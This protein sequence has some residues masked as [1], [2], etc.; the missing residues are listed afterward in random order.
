MKKTL[1]LLGL[2]AL[3]TSCVSLTGQLDVK[4]PL[5]VKK[6]SG[7]LNLKRKLV[8][9]EPGHYA[10]EVKALGEKNFNLTLLGEDNFKV[11]LATEADIKFPTKNGDIFVAGKDIDQPFDIAG[12]IKTDYS[13]GPTQDVIESCTW[14]ATE[15]RCEKV[16]RTIQVDNKP[17]Q[18]CDVECHQ[19]QVSYPGYQR[20]LY[21]MTT[22][23]R[24]LSLRLLSAEKELATFKGYD[25]ET[26]R[27]NESV[28]VCR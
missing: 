9:L 1:A 10:A 17:V 11:P 3:L 16:C 26:Y 13:Y 7:F 27:V 5:Q 4:E 21:H 6:K 12:T 22:I 14:Y 25:T 23:D 8:T 24:D 15:N 18:K 2:G 20:V 28:G 19:V